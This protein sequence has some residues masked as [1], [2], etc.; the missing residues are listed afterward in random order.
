MWNLEKW[1]WWTYFHG[2]NGDR[3]VENGL[4]YAVGQGESGTNDK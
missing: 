2:R 4:A 3:D 1:Y